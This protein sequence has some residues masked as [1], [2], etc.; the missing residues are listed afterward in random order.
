MKRCLFVL[1]VLVAAPFA[2]QEKVP[3]IPFDS[4]P[5]FFK[6]PRRAQFRRGCGR[7]G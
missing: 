7:S 6:L 4:V 1:L 2:A 3:E 5:D